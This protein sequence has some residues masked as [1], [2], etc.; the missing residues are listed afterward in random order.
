MP[1]C[2]ICTYQHSIA[3]IDHCVDNYVP[4]VLRWFEMGDLASLIAPRPLIVVAG[5]KDNIFPI[6]PTQ[7][8]F[9]TIHNIYTAAGAPER[10]R[11]VI[12]DEG[13]QFYPEQAWPIFNQLSGWQARS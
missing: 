11:L 8:N 9:Q 5:R 3:T 7:T 2:A 12:G 13:H 6:E 4:G 1:S 10:C